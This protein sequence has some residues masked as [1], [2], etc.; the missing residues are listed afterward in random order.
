MKIKYRTR[1]AWILSGV[2]MAAVLNMIQFPLSTDFPL[3][4]RSLIGMNVIIG[5]FLSAAYLSITKIDYIRMEEG[6]LSI[7]R[8]FPMQRKKIGSIDVK[9]AIL[10]EEAIILMLRD[11]SKVELKYKFIHMDDFEKLKE[12]VKRFTVI[13]D[14][15]DTQGGSDY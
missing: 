8:G 1:G 4:I 5:S 15:T 11:E 6:V 14:Q 13:E 2:M 12:A 7:H 9:K 3:F 10:A